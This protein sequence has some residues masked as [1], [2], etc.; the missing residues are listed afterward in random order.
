M[1]VETLIPAAWLKATGEVFD[2]ETGG[3]DWNKALAIANRYIDAWMG[4]PGA[5]WD[6]TYH[7][8]D[9]GPVA[10][11]DTFVLDASIY[12]V[13][14]DAGDPVRIVHTDGNHTDYVL[15]SAG[16]LNRY[17]DR[18]CARIGRQLKFAK[19]FTE[20][21]PQFGGTLQVPG[22]VK[23]DY[24]VNPDDTIPIDDPNWLV[25]VTAAELARTDLTQAQNYPLI[26]GEANNAMTA[27]KQA[28]RPQLQ[29]ITKY[30]VAQGTRW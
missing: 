13:S 26:I 2:G 16:Q 20:T 12:R 3:E 17:N 24:L 28:N 18:A 27:M 1:T 6:S 5:D 25:L 8:V 21:D 4:E 11:T 22:Y 30:P 19:A 14:N 9:C 10:A 15:V 23:P 29:A 7:T